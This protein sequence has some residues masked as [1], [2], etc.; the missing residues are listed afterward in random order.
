MLLPLS[1]TGYCAKHLVNPLLVNFRTM[2][3]RC[4][5][6]RRGRPQQ[7][8]CPPTDHAVRRRAPNYL[9]QAEAKPASGSGQNP[10]G[11]KGAKGSR[12][13][14]GAAAAAVAGGRSG[15]AS[16]PTVAKGTFSVQESADAKTSRRSSGFKMADA[17]A[18]TRALA[19][20]VCTAAWCVQLTHAACAIRQSRSYG[21]SSV[22]C[23]QRS[24]LGRPWGP[25]SVQI[26]THIPSYFENTTK[27][28]KFFPGY[29][30]L[31]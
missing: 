27:N 14:A 2:S 4:I 28:H 12:S 7:P 8:R 20:G 13:D 16:T 29:V 5:S 18:L 23:G 26:L 17:K 10:R 30:L 25:E 6:R 3:I 9:T 22:R 15:G 24:R 1:R 31:Y 21:F 11:A 19:K